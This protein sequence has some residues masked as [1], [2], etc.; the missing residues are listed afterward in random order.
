MMNYHDMN[1]GFPKPATTD[2]DG[3]PLLSCAWRSCP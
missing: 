1:G 2:K 3:K